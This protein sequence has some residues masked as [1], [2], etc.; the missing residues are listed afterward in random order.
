MFLESRPLPPSLHDHR[1]LPVHTVSKNISAQ[2]PLVRTRQL[3][4][5]WTEQVNLRV[6]SPKKLVFI[7]I[8]YSSWVMLYSHLELSTF[9][10]SSTRPNPLPNI[11]KTDKMHLNY[12]KVFTAALHTPHLHGPAQ[13]A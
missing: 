1:S 13:E 11:R 8:H 10:S 2:L 6:R 7:K 4:A 5:V 3:F 9:Q 12:L